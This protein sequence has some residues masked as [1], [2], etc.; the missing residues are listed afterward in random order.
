[1]S[2]PTPSR[3]SRPLPDRQVVSGERRCVGICGKTFFS[4]DRV[5]QQMCS[6]CRRRSDG[7]VCHGI[8]DSGWRRRAR[9][10]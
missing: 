5:R 6:D 8:I 1:M 3:I 4:E 10:A 7:F 9:T 2:M